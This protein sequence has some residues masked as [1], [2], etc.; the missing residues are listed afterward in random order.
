M[1]TMRSAEAINAIIQTA[2][3]AEQPLRERLK[4]AY[5]TDAALDQF[6]NIAVANWSEASDQSDEDE[7]EPMLRTRQH[8]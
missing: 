3:E 2:R 4:T 6:I 1:T 7:Q 5:G 8:K